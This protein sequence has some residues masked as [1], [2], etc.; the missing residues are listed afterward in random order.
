M[1][2]V[3][4]PANI[5]VHKVSCGRRDLFTNYDR[6]FIFRSA[7]ITSRGLSNLAV[8]EPDSEGRSEMSFDLSMEEVIRIFDL[9]S[10][11]QSIGAT[12]DLTGVHFCK[13]QKCD[14]SCGPAT[15]LCQYGVVVGK[16]LTGSAAGFAQIYITLDGGGTW[17]PAATNPFGAGEDIGAVTCFLT[18]RN[19]VRILVARGSA[20]AG[21]AEVAYSDDD[22]ATWTV[23]AVGATNAQYVNQAEGLFAL[24]LYNIWMVT[25]GGYI[26]HSEDSG[27]SWTAQESGVL[28]A[29]TLNAVVFADELNGYAA[30]N[31]NVIMSSLDGGV[32][33]TLL[34]GPAGK[35]ADHVLALEV[36]DANKAWLGYSDGELWYTIDGGTT[37]HQ[38]TT[39]LFSGGTIDYLHFESALIGWMLHN[40]AGPVGTVY[41]SIDGGFTWE[42]TTMPTNAG[43][44]AIHA[45]DPNLAFVVGDVVGGTGFVGKAFA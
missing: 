6:S 12:G 13:D 45:C 31:T 16:V 24:D 10:A 15:G 44:Y 4:C 3:V 33:W 42:A 20:G 38:R 29:A 8:R 40:T 41:R 26:Y 18:A 7:S 35:G 21:P 5:F 28:T 1:E 22:G 11:Q 17:T 2:R 27:E 9:A 43:L 37:W 36:I 23:V 39:A 30:G 32:S 19:T 25:N 34:T 14:D